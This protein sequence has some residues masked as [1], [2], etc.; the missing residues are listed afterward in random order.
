MGKEPLRELT[1]QE[2][3]IL[4]KWEEM[5]NQRLREQLMERDRVW[6]FFMILSSLATAL[7]VQRL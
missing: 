4:A 6:L 5:Y 2:Q 3:K 7:I 1:D